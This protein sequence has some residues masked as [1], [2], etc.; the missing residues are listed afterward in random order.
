MPE[1]LNKIAWPLPLPL[2]IKLAL[3][4]LDSQDMAAII[5]L[6]LEYENTRRV[7]QNDSYRRI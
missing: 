5:F 6:T 2:A 4:K 1:W 7:V 3:G